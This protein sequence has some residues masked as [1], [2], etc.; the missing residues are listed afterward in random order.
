MLDFLALDDAERGFVIQR[1]QGHLTWLHDFKNAMS[2]AGKKF[3]RDTQAL[4]SAGYRLSPDGRRPNVCKSCKQLFRKGC[5]D[6]YGRSN[7]AVKDVIF[8]MKL[9]AIQ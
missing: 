8:D 4:T 9:T 6:E 1:V 2:A 7:K 5:C 3:A